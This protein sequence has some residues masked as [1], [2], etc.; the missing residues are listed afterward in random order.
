MSVGQVDRVRLTSTIED[1][2]G[3]PANEI[4]EVRVEPGSVRI[5]QLKKREKGGYWLDE[6]DFFITD[7][8][9]EEE[10]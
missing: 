2:F 4:R 6:H 3:I 8:D 5:L 1:L 10:E 7:L 9:S